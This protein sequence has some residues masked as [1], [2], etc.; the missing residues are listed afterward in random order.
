MN[1]CTRTI[2]LVHLGKK[3]NLTITNAY[4]HIYHPNRG[5]FSIIGKLFKFL[6]LNANGQLSNLVSVISFVLSLSTL[7]CPV[8]VVH[9][10]IRYWERIRKKGIVRPE[11]QIE[12]KREKEIWFKKSKARRTYNE[13]EIN[14]KDIK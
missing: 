9:T 13:N 7:I 1:L 5:F 4:L 2:Q 6:H 14:E 3:I 11:R 12:W 10:N 8:H